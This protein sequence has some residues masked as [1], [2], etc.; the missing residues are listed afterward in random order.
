[1]CVATQRSYPLGCES[2]YDRRKVNDETAL[3]I[4]WTNVPN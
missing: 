1:M 4:V 3:G 2:L